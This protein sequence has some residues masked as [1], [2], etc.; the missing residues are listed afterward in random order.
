[1]G[2]IAGPY[3][4]K[5]WLHVAPY[6][7]EPVTYLAYPRWWIGAPQREVEV[8]EARRHGDAII[9]RLAGY[10]DREAAEHLRGM[11]IEVPRAALPPTG[12]DEVYWT[13]LIGLRVMNDAGEDLGEVSEVFAHA[14]HAV[15]RVRDEAAEHLIP[16]VPAYVREVHLGKRHIHVD[17]ECDW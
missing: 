12:E 1:M 8:L 2:R 3:G 10:E 16:F 15:L 4:V 9:A 11:A 6:T 7:E 14:G 5:S 17:W 13:D